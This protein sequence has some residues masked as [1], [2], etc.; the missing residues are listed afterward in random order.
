MAMVIAELM[1]HQHKNPIISKLVK[2]IERNYQYPSN[3]IRVAVV[4][5]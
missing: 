3:I 1:A 2:L 5:L 4:I